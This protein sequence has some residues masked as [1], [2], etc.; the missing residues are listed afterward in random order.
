MTDNIS[1]DSSINGTPSIKK[2]QAFLNCQKMIN[3]YVITLGLRQTKVN[4]FRFF[5]VRSFS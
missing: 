1:V 4:C 5:F 3:R 2:H